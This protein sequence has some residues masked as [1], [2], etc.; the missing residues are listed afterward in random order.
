M[1]EKGL[2]V[3]LNK[4]VENLSELERCFVELGKHCYPAAIWSS[5][6]IRQ[7]I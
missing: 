3:D 1:G 5:W 7:T 6:I 2:E 4:R